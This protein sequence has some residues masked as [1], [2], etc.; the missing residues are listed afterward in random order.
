MKLRTPE[1]F[2]LVK[3]GILNS[4]PS[5]KEDLTTE[6][7]II[8][9]GITGSLIAHQCIK[10]GFEVVIADRRE[11]AN[12]STSATTSM[13]Q[14][15]IDVPLYELSEMVGKK[16][17][18]QC[19]QACL[20]SIEMLGDLCKE[21]KSDCE[22]NKK[23]SLF[24]ANLKKDVSWL[25]KEFNARKEAGFPVTWVEAEEIEN[26]YKVLN[27]H[28][29][30]LSK[31]GASI[32]AFTFAHDLLEFN[33]KKGLKIFD[34]TNI[35]K[36][37]YGRAGIVATTE[38]G[39]TIKAKKIIYCNGFESTEIIKEDFVKL[40]STYASVSERDKN[41]YKN[42]EDVLLWNTA[43]PYLYMRTT[44]D[45]RLLVG[46]EDEDFVNAEKRDSLLH[47]KSLK[48]EKA[49]AKYLNIKDYRTDFTWAGT[50]GETKDGLP[51]IGEHKK[52]PGAFFVL[53]F[54]GNGI[55]FSVIGMKIISDLLKGKNNEL[56]HWFRFGR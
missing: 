9:G 52:F 12:G 51:Y 7:L 1:A 11:I 41:N 26:K 30:I 48:L 19:Y 24:F 14:Y 23:D 5:L 42:I 50:F 37:K 32:D 47:Q 29:G 33:T 17:A 15:E 10:E 46:G 16:A 18:I 8:G 13:L 55:T 53:G 22:F 43:D 31:A 4:Y 34:K 20:D 36:V 35:T 40:L 6:I 25:K 49:V 28:G 21:I 39:N 56:A 38:H 44:D 2:W 45:G 3:N 27:T 54:G